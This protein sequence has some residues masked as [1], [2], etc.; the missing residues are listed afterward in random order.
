MFI[1]AGVD[2]STNWVPRVTRDRKLVCGFKPTFSA[3]ETV[4]NTAVAAP[5]VI[6]LTP[7]ESNPAPTASTRT[8]AAAAPVVSKP[9]TASYRSTT[10]VK[11]VRTTPM[12]APV[13]PPAP[14]PVITEVQTVAATQC[15]G[16]N[17]V[18]A[19]Y[20]THPS[21]AVRCGPQAQGATSATLAASQPRR[22]GLK[23]RRAAQPLIPL[24]ASAIVRGQVVV[25]GQVPGNTRVVPRHVYEARGN[26]VTVA[27]PPRG[28]KSVWDDD[29]LNPRRAEQTFNGKAKMEMI[30]TNTVPRRLKSVRARDVITVPAGG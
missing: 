5:T 30:W 21:A 28:Y 27:K 15:T 19:R 18:S 9:A 23:L 14:A 13:A 20:Q 7:E 25:E 1:R 16:G 11:A 6:T 29:R 3:G 2:G 4:R 12:L 10:T 22:A 17:A 8:V 24:P 26:A